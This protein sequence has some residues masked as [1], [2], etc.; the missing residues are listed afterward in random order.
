[1]YP[2]NIVG[3]PLLI[4][5]SYPTPV[6]SCII[7]QSC[8]EFPWAKGAKSS[9]HVH[10]CTHPRSKGN[11]CLNFEYLPTVSFKAV[12][13]LQNSARSVKICFFFFSFFFF[14]W[15][16]LSVGQTYYGKKTLKYLVAILHVRCSLFGERE[17]RVAS[18]Y[19][20]PKA[21]DIR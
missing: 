4:S 14:Y 21:K 12:C 13:Y 18:G 19:K 8:Y 3:S 1:M 10:V 5:L 7:R 2:T 9:R 15:F 11:A 20:G 17:T 16:I 6:R